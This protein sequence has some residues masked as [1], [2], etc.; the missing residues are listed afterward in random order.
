M[1]IDIRAAIFPDDLDEVRSIFREYADSLNIDLEFQEFATEIA[2]LPGK[3]QPPAGRLLLAWKDADVVGCVAMRS[4][5]ERTCE[6][7]RLYVRPAVRGEQLGRRLAGRICEE[8]RN[9][10]YA[11]ICL[12][13]LPSMASAQKLY[14]SLGFK[15][16]DPYTFNPISGTQFLALDLD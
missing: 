8:A 3:Y 6:M 4:L 16:I 1:L 10:R 15:P 13:T 2:G 7:K 11:R 9:A 5:D 12:D 14:A